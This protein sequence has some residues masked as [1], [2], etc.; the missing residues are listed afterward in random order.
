MD[1]KLYPIRFTKAIQSGLWAIQD[2]KNVKI[3]FRNVIDMC[4]PFE[5]LDIKQG[6]K[7]EFFFANTNFGIKDAFSPQDI[8]L[9]IERP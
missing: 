5:D 7:L 2:E 9:N 8:M 4:I 3:S 6:E 1:K